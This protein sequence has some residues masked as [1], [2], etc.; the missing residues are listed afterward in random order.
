ML[1][2][3][4]CIVS[5]SKN[6]KEERTGEG[7]GIGRASMRKIKEINFDEIIFNL[8]KAKIVFKLL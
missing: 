2:M 8:H 6:F 3:N 4:I 1:K 5:I 7:T